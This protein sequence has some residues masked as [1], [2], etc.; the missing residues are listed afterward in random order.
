MR[1]Q[2]LWSQ[3]IN[4]VA[5]KLKSAA[6]QSHLILLAALPGNKHLH[7]GKTMYPA[8]AAARLRAAT[9]SPRP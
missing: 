4:L 3:E 9:C 6:V 8:R 7:M 2:L 1:Q 5:G